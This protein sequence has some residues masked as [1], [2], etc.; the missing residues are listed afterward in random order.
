MSSDDRDER[1]PRSRSWRFAR[2]RF[3][4]DAPSDAEGELA[5]QSNQL[6]AQQIRSARFIERA[7]ATGGV[8]ALRPS[9]TPQP[10]RWVAH[11]GCSGTSSMRMGCPIVVSARTG[12]SGL[13]RQSIRSCG[14]VTEY[15]EEFGVINMSRL[16]I[17]RHTGG[18]GW[19]GSS[20]HRWSG[21]RKGRPAPDRARNAVRRQPRRTRTG[22]RARAPQAVPDRDRFATSWCPSGPRGH[23]RRTDTG[24]STGSG[25]GISRRSAVLG[26][27]RRPPSSR[28]RD[29][30][31]NNSA[32][33]IADDAHRTTA[34]G[35]QEEY[36]EPRRGPPLGGT[37]TAPSPPPRR[38]S[39]MDGTEGRRLRRARPGC[40]VIIDRDR[41]R[42][43]RGGSA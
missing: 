10:T 38:G 31:A 25:S 15:A 43:T 4:Q 36:R 5:V 40:V 21:G 30:I 19:H 11:S 17:I 35:L 14:T 24:R 8:P 29:P 33:P 3:M 2:T 13:A 1:C 6:R 39:S 18:R 9:T 12:Q 42:F 20:T 27:K 34:V 37:A 22:A 16:R 26:A 32:W 41:I 28:R 7:M 23:C